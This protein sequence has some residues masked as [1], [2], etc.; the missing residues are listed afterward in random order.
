MQPLSPGQPT[1]VGPYR[2]LGRLGAGGMGEVY[3]GR[4]PGGRTAAIKLVHAELASDPEFRRRFRS[5]VAAAQRVSGEWTAPVLDSDTESTVP[6]VATGYVPGPSLTQVV[7]KYGPLP[8]ESVWALTH[9]LTQALTDIHGNGLVHRDLKPSNV[10]ITLD[11]PKVIDFGI[12]R[13]VDASQATRTGSMVGS[14]GYMAPEQIRGEHIT[15]AADIFALGAVVAYAVSGVSPF[16]PDQPSLHTV[17]YRVLHEEPELGAPEGP[18]TGYLRQVAERCLLKDPGER[19]T[20]PQILQLAAHHTDNSG[21]WLPPRLTAQLGRDAA[22]LLALDGPRDAPDTPPPSPAPGRGQGTPPPYPASAAPVTGPLTGSATHG[23]NGPNGTHAPTV[24]PPPPPPSRRWRTPLLAGA[25]V[26]TLVGGAFLVANQF[27]G[28]DDGPPTAGGDPTGSETG[29]AEEPDDGTDGEPGEDP[30]DDTGYPGDPDAPFFDRLPEEL[31]QEGKITVRA[32]TY[33]GALMYV[34]PDTDIA[35]VEHDLALEIGERLGLRID[36]APSS[37]SRNLMTAM[38]TA[39]MAGITSQFAMGG[40]EDVPSFRQEENVNFVNHIQE[41][42]TLLVPVQSGIRSLDDMCGGSV[43]TWQSDRLRSI[44]EHATVGCREPVELR[45][46][47]TT[48][49][50]ESLVQAGQVDGMLV[51]YSGARSFVNENPDSGLWAT[52]DHVGITVRGIAVPEG[53]SELRDLIQA[54]VQAMMDDGTYAEILEE[55]DMPDL[56]IDGATVNR[57]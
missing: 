52:S 48:Q 55:W 33:A 21:V 44:V 14:P 53:A 47:N 54:A 24:P 16:A 10:L 56:A 7:G 36:F 51:S 5:E 2:L 22:S 43:V 26:L 27:G 39:A 57:G 41:G 34:D 3:L 28:G 46:A 15:S 29:P 13:A 30:T 25:V 19:P 1:S 31:R 9:G 32:G 8:E 11:G 12:A 50:M 4:S 20:L 38:R 42:M 45:T 49:E 40:L 23:P 6:W 17:L 35:G 18:L 37:D